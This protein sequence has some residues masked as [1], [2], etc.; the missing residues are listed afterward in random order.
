MKKTEYF[1]DICGEKIEELE[2]A[3]GIYFITNTD[4]QIGNYG[5]TDGVHICGSCLSQLKKH[6]NN[7]PDI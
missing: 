3:S 7:I 4:F 6:L 2:R 1:C 5:C